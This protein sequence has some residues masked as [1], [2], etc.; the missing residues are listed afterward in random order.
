[1]SRNRFFLVVTLLVFS[2]S[3]S[4]QSASLSL[5]PQ[6]ASIHAVRF[7]PSYYYDAPVRANVL[8]EQLAETWRLHG[9]NV[10]FYKAYDPAHGA[11]YRTR[12]DLNVEADYGRHNLLKYI[13]KACSRRDIQVVAWLPALQ[14]QPAWEQHPEW[15]VKNPDGTDYQL[16]AHHF[17]LCAAN[18]GVRTWW[19]GFLDD[20]LK[21]YPGL[22]GIDIAEPVVRWQSACCGCAS[23]ARQKAEIGWEDV[24]A[25]GLN[26]TLSAGFEKIHHY[27]KIA[28][29]TSVV[30]PKADGA[31]YS[32]AE[33]RGYTG[34]DLDALLDH[35]HKPDWISLELMWQQWADLYN[36][37]GLFSPE[38]VLGAAAA[39]KAQ[40]AGRSRLLVHLE[41]TPFAAHHVDA[42][43]L[44]RSIV[45]AKQAETPDIDLYD[46]HQ[47][48]RAERWPVVRE[49]FAWQPLRR[50]LIV[51]DPLGD[52][53]ARQVASLLSH[54]RA[55][56]EIVLLQP[57]TP[58]SPGRLIE[59]SHLFYIGVD[60]QFHLPETFIRAAAAF[61]GSIA[62]IHFGI[63][64]FLQHPS[65]PPYGFAHNGSACDSTWNR[66]RYQSTLLPKQDPDFHQIVITDSARCTIHAWLEKGTQRLP[67]ALHSGNLWYFADLT[68]AFVLEGGSYI[69]FA[70]LL[71][72]IIGENHRSNRLA[73]VRIEDITPLSDIKALKA[74]AD[75][76]CGEDVPFSISLVP[77]YLDPASNT[78]V[79]L[80]DQP[81]FVKA[82]HYMVRKGGVIVMHGYTHQYRGETTADYEF[83]DMMQNAPLF[84][85]SRE[86]VRERIELGLEELARNGLYPV[87]WETPHY[88]ASQLDYSVINHYFSSA[89]ER[90]QTIDLHGSDQL[91]PWLISRHTAG[92][93]IIPENLGY[94]PLSRPEAGPL[95]EAARNHLALR[96][97][98]ASFFF[99]PFVD[100][101]VLKEIIPAMK[102]M[103]Y[104]FTDPRHTTQQVRG[105]TFRVLTGSG[106]V[107]LPLASAYAQEFYVDK[108]GK[109]QD[110]MLSEQPRSDT[111]RKRVTVPEG[112]LYVATALPQKPP[113]MLAG[114]V[115]DVLRRVPKLE[116]Y[117][118]AEQPLWSA[119]EQPPRAI[120]L[121]AE[122]AASPLAP[123]HTPWGRALES[124]GI[125]A[126]PHPVDAFLAVPE[127]SN[128]I[129][130]PAAAALKLN[131]QQTLLL[132]R[133]V[134]NG[135]NI[136]LER[137]SELAAA[138]GILPQE[139][140]FIAR[141]ITDEYYPTVPIQW[142]SPDTLMDFDTE[143]DY[144]V[145]ASEPASGKP[146][147]IGGEYG[148]GRYLYF[149]A[150][151]DVGHD[152]GHG[153]FPFLLEMMRYQFALKPL[154]RRESVEIYFDPG[155]REEISIEDL[156]KMWRKNGVRTI[157]AAGWH[158]YPDYAYDYGRLIDLAHRNAMRVYLWLQ[159][160]HLS[161]KFWLDHPSWREKNALNA[162][163]DTLGA[164]W[165]RPMAL[166]LPECRDAV[167]AELQRLLTAHAWDGIN[168]AEL[169]FDSPAGAAAP[170]WFTPMNQAFRDGF[171]SSHGFDPL[172]LFKPA[173]PRHWQRDKKALAAL[174]SAREELIIQL[175]RQF[176]A[177]FSALPKE[178]GYDR[179]I[180]VT[181]LDA[182]LAPDA[183]SRMGVRIEAL[184]ALCAE[185]A[186]TLQL[187]EPP[188]VHLTG[189][190]DYLRM[191]EKSRALTG[192]LSPM[193][194]VNLAERSPAPF[195][196]TR[197]ITGL[198]LYRTLAEG[199]RQGAR[200]AFNSEASLYDVDSRY[201]PLALAA[202]A[203]ESLQTCVWHIQAVKAVALQLDPKR[204]PDVLVNGS[205]WPGYY[206]GHLILPAGSHRI[207]PM[208]RS[209]ALLKAFLAEGR[210]IALS[211]ELLELKRIV[212]GIDLRYRSRTPN[213][214][215]LSEKPHGMVVDGQT[216]H[217]ELVR[218]ELGYAFALPA[219][220]HRAEIMIT[221]RTTQ[222]MKQ[223]SLAL[224]GLIAAGGILFGTALGILWFQSSRARRKKNKHA[225]RQ[226]SA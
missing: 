44:Q 40:V 5:D 196:T 8:A 187:L 177:F 191:A 47:I 220:E 57:G 21:N 162:E 19:L 181:T 42:E 188:G 77:F 189:P 158:D 100:I 33:Q 225:K 66:V 134:Q 141:G 170:E 130:V 183:T 102:Q 195:L 115:A 136:I 151:L 20:L 222:L 146:V 169:Y 92:G 161:E 145:Y 12:Y 76:L 120:L 178:N 204:H 110:R 131:Q 91:L 63:D 156:I 15:R 3:A 69:V 223:I 23:C 203:R 219:G 51:T 174:Y 140:T 194:T 201:L 84:A 72:D 18:P 7:D 14:H 155:S 88:G 160:P 224:S 114:L 218:G 205:L 55:E 199:E 211:G 67:Y 207:Q 137:P 6:P 25:L 32:S 46:T 149:S 54:F 190:G 70:D 123:S 60:P 167:M 43:R 212:R 4:P 96:D 138:L 29:A 10:L 68:T 176:L 135:A 142:G 111:L 71:H 35:P 132:I 213:W 126:V 80:S 39:V 226:P 74:I 56:T 2:K 62:W 180:I 133:S 153:R 113:G 59:K 117:V 118:G 31:L 159:L 65:A 214:V 49:A 82:I 192:G 83:W 104:R 148:A 125:D 81:D 90:R 184:A 150:H 157:H 200:L 124:A 107:E 209:R 94:I 182:S 38:W 52:N 163:V 186:C 116:D 17:P 217:P 11:K 198:E 119:E 144:V 202:A 58:F 78:A 208:D 221:S 164:R 103:G 41:L 95:L 105:K 173:S 45:A 193:M 172:E 108:A 93:K 215:M 13:L 139:S 64:R 85:D 86:Y 166:N 28:C 79:S 128:L 99:H 50:I 216:I 121:I 30:S 206:R 179:E 73:M 197:Q 89:Y 27:G 112:W 37:P 168:L 147:V 61:Q 143:F 185:S 98:V 152:G 97:G 9:V 24:S 48:D 101:A 129:V 171:R 75:Y 53:D 122:E 109:I 165:R 87:T 16:D 210:L 106:D 34:F 36:N 175:H 1:M 154:V 127:G 22:A 26:K